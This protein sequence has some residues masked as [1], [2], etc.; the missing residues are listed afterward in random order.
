M[1][2]PLTTTIKPSLSHPKTTEKVLAMLD[3]HALAGKR[4]LDL[5]AGHGYFTSR[6][7]AKL[8]SA[9][10]D[11]APVLTACDLYPREY[12]FTPVRCDHADFGQHLSYD[13]GSFD[14]VICMEVIEHLPNQQQLIEEIGRILKPGGRAILT[15]PNILNMAGR[16][17]FLLTGTW[18]LFDILPVSRPD[19]KAVA[20]H[21]GPISLYYLYYFARLAGFTKVDFTVDRAKKSAIALAGPMYPLA[22]LAE[23]MLNKRRKREDYFAENLPATEALNAWKTLVGRT[24]IMDARR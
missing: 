12:Q 13:D 9:G 23:V 10:V 8:E 24:I 3:P 20:G 4:V 16:L 11:P 19:V 7:W 17:R 15:T 6:L 1:G 22:C 18:P 14:L 2:T 21:I 5:G